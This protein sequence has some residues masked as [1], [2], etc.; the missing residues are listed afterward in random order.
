MKMK[1]VKI[2]AEN[3]SIKHKIM[4]TGMAPKNGPNTGITL[5][6][7]SYGGTSIVFLLAEMGLVLNVSTMVR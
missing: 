4:M 1:I 3:G 7:V 2:K 5:P 6:F